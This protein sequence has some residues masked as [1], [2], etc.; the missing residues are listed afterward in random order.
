MNKIKY[1]LI[2]LEMI[3]FIFSFIIGIGAAEVSQWGQAFLLMFGPFILGKILN[4]G[5]QIEFLEIYQRAWN[6]KLKSR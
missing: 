4:F 1:I 3:A 5:K 6:I 2:N